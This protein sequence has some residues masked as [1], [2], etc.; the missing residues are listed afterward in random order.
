MDFNFIIFL[1]EKALFTL[2]SVNV[3]VHGLSV[4]LLG[5]HP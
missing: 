2:M 1:L 5:G 3:Y 4:V